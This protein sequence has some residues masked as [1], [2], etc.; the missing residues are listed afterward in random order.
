[1]TTQELIHKFKHT[2]RGDLLSDMDQE[3][4]TNAVIVAELNLAQ[5]EIAK[6]SEFT[7]PAL[8]IQIQAPVYTY[9]I[10]NLNATNKIRRIIRAWNPS[11]SQEYKPMPMLDLIRQYP[12]Y[13][14]STTEA[15][16]FG[17]W[18][19]SRN[20]IFY[21]TPT[22]ATTLYV[23]AECD[24]APLSASSLSTVS[25][26]DESLHYHISR[27]A[28]ARTA[29]VNVSTP[30]Q[31]NVIASIIKEAMEAAHNHRNDALVNL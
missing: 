25:E 6:W 5:N 16:P 15:N 2:L 24:P 1:M 30:A 12:K 22:V 9:T 21:P 18:I 3:L 7:K 17:L 13:L 19:D 27:L 31:A 26:L 20:A 23:H 28:A 4:G 11:D 10:P 14:V 8:P 29:S